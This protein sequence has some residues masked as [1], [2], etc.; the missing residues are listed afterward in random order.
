MD[1]V[2]I[3]YRDND[4]TPMIF[5]IQAVAQRHYG[6]DVEVIQI[7]DESAFEASIFDGTADVLIEHTEYL[8]AEAV[9]GKKVMMFCAPVVRTGLVLVVP[10]EVTDV[11][12]LHG[13]RVAVRFPGRPTATLL[14]IRHLGL[15]GLVEPVIVPDAEVGRWMQWKRVVSGEYI[16]AFLTGDFLPAALAAGLHVLPV[17]DIPNVGLYAQACTSEYA[18][19]NDDLMRRY[20]SAVIHAACLMKLRPA[21]AIEIARGEPARRLMHEGDPARRLQPEDEA[22]EMERRVRLTADLLQIKP[23]PSP[24][25]IA[26]AY[27]IAVEEWPGGKGINPLTLWDLH[28]VKQLDDE[29][30]IDNL[31]ASME[32]TPA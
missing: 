15:T 2:R 22:A 31:A 13:K 17:E 8:L 32:T 3:A 9:S 14:R 5:C 11:A 25:G 20:V 23:Y 7:R 19:A 30:F 1:R 27:E 6:I 24:A 18:R 4:R 12:Q 16:G 28:W 10:P 29:G 21:E 26:N